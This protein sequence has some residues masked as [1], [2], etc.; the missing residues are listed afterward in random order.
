M[1]LVGARRL[2]ASKL[3]TGYTVASDWI[4]QRLLNNVA[5]SLALLLSTADCDDIT[6][7]V[8]IADPSSC[9]LILLTSYLL[10]LDSFNS[11]ADVIIAE[12]FYC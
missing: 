1:E 3:A 10:I 6:T 9:L 5:P 7:E 4:T 11:N 2:D 12:Y 8:I